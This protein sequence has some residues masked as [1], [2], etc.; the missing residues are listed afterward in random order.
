MIICLSIWRVKILDQQTTD[1]FLSQARSFFKLIV[2]TRYWNAVHGGV[3][4]SVTR[5]TQPNPYL[6]IPERDIKTEDGKIL[7][8]IN[9]A[10]MT[11]QIAETA[12]ARNQVQFHITS[13]K[14]LRPANA[15]AK[16]EAGAL[17]GF[18]SRGG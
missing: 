4:V 11:R 10:Y 1:V 9:P 18:S 12:S 16:W 17:S 5:D 6:D 14:P 13:L 2:T 15:P 3:Y 7:T 8:L